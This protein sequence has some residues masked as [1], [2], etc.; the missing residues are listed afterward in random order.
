MQ[1]SQQDSWKNLENHKLKM[2]KKSIFDL[3]EDKNRFNKLSFELNNILFDFSKQLI[4]KETINLFSK[5]LEKLDYKDKIN[6]MFNGDSINHT[7]NRKA[8]HVGLREE[9][10]SPEVRD[11]LRKIELIVNNLRNNTFF[12]N[13]KN[14]VT[15]IISIGIGGSDLGPRMVCNALEPYKQSDINIHFISN[16]D[17]LSLDKILKK[18]NPNQTIAIINSKSFSTIETL[19]IAMQVRAWLDKNLS[20]TTQ[21]N[22]HLLAVTANK[23]KAINFGINSNNILELWD[24][25]GGRFS[26]WSA[27]G[28]PIAI[29]IGFDNFK[30]FLNGAQSVDKHFKNTEISKNI[31]ILMAIIG[32]WNNN[33]LEHR[34]HAVMPYLDSLGLFPDYLQQLE[35]ESNGKTINVFGKLVE[36]HTA[37]VLWGGVGCNNQ[38]AYMQLLHQGSQTIPTDFILCVNPNNKTSDKDLD[39]LLYASSVGQSLALIKGNLTGNEKHCHGNKPNT[40]IVLPEVSPKLLGSLIATYEHKVFV[41]GIIWQIQSF[42]QWGVELG[43]NLIKDLLPLI[44][45]NNT[46]EQ[47]Q[48]KLDSST[49][50]LLQYYQKHSKI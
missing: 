44:K 1:I 46:L 15:D 19:S 9:K 26:V 3:F 7:E 37:P 4:D 18:L 2:Q 32:I 10:Q 39:N 45:D 5:L 43:K 14:K 13:S 23:E 31:P 35:M 41:Q 16:S 48:N 27:V 6:A 25:V 17:S 29:S 12:S 47:Q 36:H 34:T 11:S 33:F 40:T 50:G 24:W 38:H 20:S 30:E 22:E 42:D 8:F 28:L 49:Y 21:T